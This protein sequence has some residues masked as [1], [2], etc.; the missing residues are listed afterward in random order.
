MLNL[1]ASRW[2]RKP[3][4]TIS[5]APSTT[6]TDTTTAGAIEHSTTISSTAA[7]IPT[8]STVAVAVEVAKIASAST[9]TPFIT[10]PPTTP[11]NV[12][13]SG[14][15][16]VSHHPQQTTASNS[17][18]PLFPPTVQI[19]NPFFPT[20]VYPSAPLTSRINVQ[21][22]SSP[23]SSSHSDNSTFT[24]KPPPSSPVSLAS[25][26]A[27]LALSTSAIPLRF[28]DF[29]L[30]TPAQ[31]AKQY[32]YQQHQQQ[33]Q[34]EKQTR[35]SPAK[36]Q[37]SRADLCL[38]TTWSDVETTSV[39]AFFGETD[40]HHSRPSPESA[41][42][43]QAVTAD[44]TTKE[45]TLAPDSSTTEIGEATPLEAAKASLSKSS[46][47]ALEPV[48]AQSPADIAF[49]SAA[50]AASIR[51]STPPSVVV[52]LKEPPKTS[53]DLKK[54]SPT[55][56]SPREQEQVQHRAS[57]P[58]QFP[59][60]TVTELEPDTNTAEQEPSRTMAN[61]TN[62]GLASKVDIPA[63]NP[64]LA[65]V[66]ACDPDGTIPDGRVYVG[67]KSHHLDRP[68][69]PRPAAHTTKHTFVFPQSQGRPQGAPEPPQ[70]QAQS[71]TQGQTQAQAQNRPVQSQAAYRPP[72]NTPPA[73][74]PNAPP[75]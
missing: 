14:A 10:T 5:T 2:A 57:L 26:T 46:E 74:K 12:S 15:S 48:T 1:S 7:P 29:P 70:S 6:T 18:R 60:P 34:Q 8:K 41:S 38:L 47:K 21:A 42:P 30:G 59:P 19:L 56:S 36:P 61:P 68:A 52:K 44:P 33:Q 64:Y 63:V 51:I 23:S 40:D 35:P 17:S 4:T 50:N 49:V 11:L 20:K 66:A 13:T 32:Q 37:Y 75:P 71:R 9:A 53:Q 28:P 62:K 43:N 39:A 16:S 45:P 58:R 72:P 25:T 27:A 54:V 31:S 69:P 24:S 67:T 73:R 55:P 22:Q 65:F 3:T